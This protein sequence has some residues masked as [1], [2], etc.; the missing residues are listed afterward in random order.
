[1]KEFY[2]KMMPQTL[3]SR[4]FRPF[5]EALIL[6]A[7]LSLSSTLALSSSTKIRV[8]QGSSC[9][10]KCRGAFDPLKSFQSL[11]KGNI[12]ES[13]VEV[14]ETFCM[15]QCKRG[16][17]ARIIRDEQV[18]TF[19][20]EMNETEMNRKSFQGVR[21]DERVGNLWGLAKGLEDG[22]VDG[23]DSGDAA[24]LTDIMPSN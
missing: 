22:T 13:F 18:I 11:Q 17:N 9:L 6:Y 15:N 23:V 7:I 1:M 20:G 12:E 19:E 24:K 2:L 14:E 16:P 4:A 10:S 5:K 21:S 8:C 3:Q